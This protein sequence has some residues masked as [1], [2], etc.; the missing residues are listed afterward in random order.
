[1][2]LLRWR[3]T[4]IPA[5][6]IRRW[7]S[8]HGR[9][10]PVG[11]EPKFGGKHLRS[12]LTASGVSSG[13]RLLVSVRRLRCSAWNSHTNPRGVRHMRLQN[14]GLVILCSLGEVGA[15]FWR[16][17]PWLQLGRLTRRSGDLIRC[18]VPFSSLIQRLGSDFTF[19]RR[20]RRRVRGW[21]REQFREH[22][23]RLRQI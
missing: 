5:W 16:Q 11:G 8:A 19:W 7:C 23:L 15:L 18:A 22:S 20:P 3:R 17:R 12:R 1:M 21:P 13:F 9:R 14:P 4:G 2:S 10:A 6:L